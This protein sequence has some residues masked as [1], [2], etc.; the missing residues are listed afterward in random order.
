MK[1]LIAAALIAVTAAPAAAL[2]QGYPGHNRGGQQGRGQHYNGGRNY[3]G[4]RQGYANGWRGDR[5]W[6][7][8]GGR[9]WSR[10]G[11]YLP[12]YYSGY[13]V[14][15]YARWR[16][17]RPPRGYYWYRTGDDFVLA[18]IASGMI[19]DIVPSGPYGQ[20]RPYGY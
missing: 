19:F 9:G 18:A 20:P 10:R 16:L 3:G 6:R 11:G 5:D 15:D 12:P 13:V 14:N 17:R 4:Q 8:H 1:A 2:A 7:G